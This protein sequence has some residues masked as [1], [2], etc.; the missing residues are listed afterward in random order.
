MHFSF[1]A[2]P[3]RP[4]GGRNNLGAEIVDYHARISGFVLGP[5][6]P[7]VPPVYP[8]PLPLRYDPKLDRFYRLTVAREINWFVSEHLRL[9]SPFALKFLASSSSVYEQ[10]LYYPGVCQRR[11]TGESE[12]I[13]TARPGILQGTRFRNSWTLWCWRGWAWTVRRRDSPV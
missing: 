3:P 11:R 12:L 9:C 5:N 6:L 7:Y 8:A 10:K 13:S 2:Q 1:V 4:H